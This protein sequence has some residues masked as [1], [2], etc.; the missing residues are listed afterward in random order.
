MEDVSAMLSA[1]Q[2]ANRNAVIWAQELDAI[3]GAG[4]RSPRWDRLS[5]NNSI[6]GL[7]STM[8]KIEEVERRFQ[9]A[10]DMAL[11]ALEQLWDLIDSL[12]DYDQKII[13][14]MRY[15]NGFTWEKIE[16]ETGW[17]N[18][19]VFRLHRLALRDLQKTVDRQKGGEC[20]EE[21][22]NDDG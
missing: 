12:A 1:Y 5:R 8:E 17:S 21:N 18:S 3:R 19:Q 6:Q 16:R 20:F 4:P 13:I 11:K 14:C 10:K 2:R 7:E 22:R 9:R 15:Y